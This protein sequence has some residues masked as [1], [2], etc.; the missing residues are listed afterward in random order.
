MNFYTPLSRAR[1]FGSARSGR[2]HWW[3]QRVTALALIP[4]SAWLA[5]SVAAL[6][7]ASHAELLAWV[8]Q[9]WNT[10]LL[11]AVAGL[12]FYH[13]M[14]GLQVIVEDYLHAPVAKIL[15]LLAVKLALGFA[16]LVA[17]YA[18]LRIAFAG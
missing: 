15:G 12:G 11:L 17:G 16:A 5:L 3:R 10:V 13:A 9:P 7:Q 8:A 1:G 6:P 2:Q 18:I 4:V 14:L